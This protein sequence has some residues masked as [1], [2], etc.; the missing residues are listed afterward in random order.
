MERNEVNISTVSLVASIL[1]G[2][3][4]ADLLGRIRNKSQKE[5]EAIVADY[6][7][8]VS[9]RDRARPVC[10]AVASSAPGALGLALSGTPTASSPSEDPTSLSLVSGAG[11]GCAPTQTQRTSECTYSR[12]WLS[13][14]C[15]VLVAVTPIASC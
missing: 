3:N 1:T 7:P 5:V 15:R 6:K 8:P 10:V 14:K 2:E 9:L 11:D 4:R 13:E 12:R